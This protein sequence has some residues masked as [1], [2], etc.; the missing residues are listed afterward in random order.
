MNK[1]DFK[2]GVHIVAYIHNEKHLGVVD[3]SE[4]HNESEYTVMVMFGDGE[5]GQLIE[6]DAEYLNVAC[7]KCYGE[8]GQDLGDISIDCDMCKGTGIEL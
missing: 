4:L 2:P 8:G 3:I 5:D 1:K 7:Q 6:V